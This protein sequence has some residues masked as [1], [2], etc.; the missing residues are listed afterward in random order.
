MHTVELSRRFPRPT[1]A[2]QRA[3]LGALGQSGQRVIEPNADDRRFKSDAWGDGHV[4]DFIKQS[5]LLASRYVMAAAASVSGVD[6]KKRE[7]INFYTRQ[8]V[9]AMAPTNFALTNPDVL[10]RTLDSQG[11]VSYTHLRA[12]ET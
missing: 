12:H 5:Y 1:P 9:D 11:A 3:A 6:D 7:Q 10:K 4:F 2:G 8:F